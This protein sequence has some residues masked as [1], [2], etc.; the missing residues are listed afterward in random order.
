LDHYT[1]FLAALTDP[2]PEFEWMVEEARAEVERLG[3]GR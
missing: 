3:R 2:N 1:T